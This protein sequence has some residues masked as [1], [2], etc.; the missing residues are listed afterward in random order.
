MEKMLER[1]I[2]VENWP[3]EHGAILAEPR[4]IHWKIEEEYG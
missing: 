1:V 4:K 2:G 3:I